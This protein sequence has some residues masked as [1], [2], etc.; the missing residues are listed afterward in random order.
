[1]SDEK[2]IAI[3]IE[4]HQRIEAHRTSFAETP[5]DILMKILGLMPLHPTTSGAVAIKDAPTK[6]HPGGFWA[7]RLEGH[8]SRFGTMFEAYKNLL[9]SLAGRN[10]SF[11]DNFAMQG[12][13]ARKFVAK[14]PEALYKA[15]PKLAQQFGLPLCDGWYFDSNLSKQQVRSRLETAAQLADLVYGR[16]IAVL[17]GDQPI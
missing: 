10:P 12:T 15:S 16:D 7:S 4:V 5:N 9:Q 13:W 2:L 3:G 11:L 1:M 8:E 6:V 14:S 17:E